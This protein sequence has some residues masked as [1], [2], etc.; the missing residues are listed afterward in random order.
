MGG[1]ARRTG[2]HPELCGG[3]WGHGVGT[4]GCGAVPP[5]CVNT[6]DKENFRLVAA[7][8][9]GDAH[10]GSGTGPEPLPGSVAPRRLQHGRA[11][12]FPSSPTVS[13]TAP[14]SSAARPRAGRRE[15]L[16]GRNRK[17]KDR[18]PSYGV[19]RDRYRLR[20]FGL[21]IRTQTGAQVTRDGKRCPP[22]LGA[23]LKRKEPRFGNTA[24]IGARCD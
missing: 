7:A 14:R 13:G 1:R 18:Q 23:S 15:R 11:P 4:A 16:R 17:R 19:P 22:T 10:G 2:R 3:R 12:P 24:G 6:K 9:L 20:R 21:A 5:R 8:A